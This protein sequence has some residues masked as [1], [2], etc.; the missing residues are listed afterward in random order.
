[1]NTRYDHKA[2]DFDPRVDVACAAA[3]SCDEVGFDTILQV[4][5]HDWHGIA[6]ASAA[7]PGRKLRLDA[8]LL[9]EAAFQVVLRFVESEMI[10]VV[11]FQG[12]SEAAEGLLRYLK[13][14]TGDA[15]RFYAVSHVTSTQ[16]QAPFE[17]RMLAALRRCRT[18]GVLAAIGSVKPHFH[19]V[20]PETWRPT[21]INF[22]PKAVS[23]LAPVPGR[24]FIPLENHWRKGLYT[25]LL[26]ALRVEETSEIRCVHEPRHLEALEDLQRVTVTGFLPRA[27]IREEMARAEVVMNVSL[28]ECQPMTQLEAYALGRPCL[29]GPL[30][31]GEFADD[32]ITKLCT[33]EHTDTP[34]GIIAKLKAL[35]AI[36]RRDPDAM[37]QMTQ[38]H[39]MRRNTLAAS[40]Y[41]EFFSL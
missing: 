14:H 34:H 18:E 29:T 1:M 41:N 31:I 17:I 32:A 23:K 30:G 37:L 3:T 24:V 21:L 16:F 12:F 4:Y 11:C 15:V 7:L 9:D 5:H 22:C 6:S 10:R 38:E 26:A 13:T 19:E 27:D 2:L 33:V 36:W 28:A 35:Y 40:R 8:N 39:V 20:M 25:N